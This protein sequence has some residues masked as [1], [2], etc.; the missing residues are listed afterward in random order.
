VGVFFQKYPEFISPCTNKWI[1]SKNFWLQRTT[2]LF[3]LNYK[4]K[5]DETLLFDTIKKFTGSTE[6]FIQKA[7][8]WA[9]REYFKTFPEKVIR[10]VNETPMA[11]LSKREALKIIK[12]NQK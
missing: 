10:F 7:I 2:I 9:L 3:Q 11:P 8:G 5:T 6:F 1:R 4:E 12:K